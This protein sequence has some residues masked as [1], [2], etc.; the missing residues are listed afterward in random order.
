DGSSGG[1]K[2]AECPVMLAEKLTAAIAFALPPVRQRIPGGVLLVG[3]RTGRPFGVQE[4]GEA[5]AL[6]PNIHQLLQ[7]SRSE[8]QTSEVYP[9]S[10]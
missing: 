8:E 4:I 6:L 9:D 3:R 10:Y 7:S 2:A 5:A 1:M